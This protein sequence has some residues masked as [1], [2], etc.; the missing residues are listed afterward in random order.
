MAAADPGNPPANP[1]EQLEQRV[2]RL[3]TAYT[4]DMANTTNT[5]V[6]MGNTDTALGQAIEEMKAKV[7]EVIIQMSTT[8]T[9]KNQ[10]MAFF[11]CSM[12]LELQSP[13]ARPRA[14]GLQGRLH[15]LCGV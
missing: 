11:A 9:Q 15:M 10:E 5:I 6:A 4:A 13:R 12:H 8:Q 2:A 3:E 14:P 1:M 7:E